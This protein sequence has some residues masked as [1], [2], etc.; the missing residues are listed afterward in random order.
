MQN[1]LP[2]AVSTTQRTARSSL[3]AGQQVDDPVALVGGD[4]VVGLGPV[5][6]D[7]GHAVVHAV[8]DLVL[9]WSFRRL[10]A[11]GSPGSCRASA[12]RVY[13]TAT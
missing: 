9:E 1:P 11:H 3:A 13:G 12:G 4:G 8:Q 2:L 5:E 6:G 10:V 7:P